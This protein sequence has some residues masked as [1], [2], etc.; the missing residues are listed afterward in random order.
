[1][2]RLLGKLQPPAEGEASPEESAER[3]LRLY[4]KRKEG[5]WGLVSVS[6]MVQYETNIHEYINKMAPTDHVLS[7]YLRQQKPKNEEEQEEPS[8]K[9]RP[10]HVSV[11]TSNDKDGTESVVKDVLPGD[12]VHS[13]LSILDTITGY[14]APYKTVS[15]RAATRSTILRLPASAFESVFKKYPETLV[16]VI[17]IIMVRLQRV[18]FLALYNY[19][20]LTTELFNPDELLARTTENTAETDGVKGQPFKQEAE[21]HLYA[22]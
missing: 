15:A 22:H 20:G 9:D 1:M 3:T 13:L 10:L 7:E 21:I 12:S 19:L 16:R 6:T 8:W 17:Q 11:F 14:P 5:G 4:A 2:K 18:T